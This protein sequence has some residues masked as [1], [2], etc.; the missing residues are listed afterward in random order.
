MYNKLTAMGLI[1]HSWATACEWQWLTF[2]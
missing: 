1:L 2:S